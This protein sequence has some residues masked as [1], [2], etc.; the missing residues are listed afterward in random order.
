MRPLETLTLKEIVYFKVRFLP[1]N[2]IFLKLW[3]QVL[4]FYALAII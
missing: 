4:N 1:I 3:K 2:E